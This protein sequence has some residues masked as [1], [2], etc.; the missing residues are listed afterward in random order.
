MCEH[1]HCTPTLNPNAGQRPTASFK[2]RVRA[3]HGVGRG[4]SPH[5]T[6]PLP[7]TLTLATTCRRTVGVTVCHIS[8]HTK[9]PQG[10]GGQL[11]RFK[12]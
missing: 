5:T 4:V 2:T 6:A 3:G 10:G 8:H 11:S 7:A 1:T 12:L 9:E